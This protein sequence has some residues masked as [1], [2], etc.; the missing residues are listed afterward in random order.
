MI[1]WLCR[2]E[3]LAQVAEAFRSQSEQ[4]ARLA[5]KGAGDVKAE[6]LTAG[7]AHKVKARPDDKPGE[8][9]LLAAAA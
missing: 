5:G 6:T 9:R 4:K 1:G 8:N 7:D 3:F 2:V